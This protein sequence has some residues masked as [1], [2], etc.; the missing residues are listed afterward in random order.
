M[1]CN[2]KPLFRIILDLKYMEIETRKLSAE[3]VKLNF[4]N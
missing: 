2:I 3:P 1:Q 4:R